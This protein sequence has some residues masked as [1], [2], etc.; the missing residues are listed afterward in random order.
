[1]EQDIHRTSA[2]KNQHYQEQTK[3]VGRIVR[4]HEGLV[5]RMAFRMHSRVSSFI[6]LD[7]LLQS[8]LEGLVDAAQKYS[9][10]EGASFESYASIR[11]KGSILDLIRRNG[12]LNRST[13]QAKQKIDRKRSEL[14]AEYGRNP[15]DEEIATSLRFTLDEYYSWSQLF[16]A[17]VS[18]SLSQ[19]YDEYS[20]VFAAETIEPERLIDSQSLRETL[21]E[22][23]KT[24]N[25]QQA[26]VLQLYYVEDLNIYEIAQVLDITPGRVSQ[27]K[28][29]A[30]KLMKQQLSDFR[31]NV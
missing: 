8:G 13:V 29:E 17:N 23:L 25:T 12:N 7:D 6:E 9:A 3:D 27:I 4:K 19:F 31:D 16:V 28:S 1:M 20:M 22:A 24:L 11:I 10:V 5:R 21:V 2:L 30:F 18:E 14:T 26:Q 15:T